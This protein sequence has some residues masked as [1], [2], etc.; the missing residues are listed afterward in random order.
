MRLTWIAALFGLVALFVLSCAHASSHDPSYDPARDRKI[1]RPPKV[2]E[3]THEAH[4]NA[5]PEQVWAV[6]VD[7]EHYADWN[8]WLVSAS[9]PAEVG[10]RVDITVVLGDKRREM[11]HRVVSVDEPHSFCWRDAGPTTSFATGLRCRE[12]VDDGAGGTDF[13]VVL[14]VGGAFRSMVRKRY[15]PRLEASMAAETAALGEE[16]ARRAA[17]NSSQARPI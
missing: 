8:P 4:F 14:T 9:G 17:A 13:R 16:V 12:L 6:L 15:G 1:P 7:F 10:A 11:W 2:V 5:P 3:W